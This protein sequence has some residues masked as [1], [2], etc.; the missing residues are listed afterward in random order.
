MLRACATEARRLAT[1][2][3]WQQAWGKR[4]VAISQMGNLPCTL[5]TGE[6]FDS[7]AAAIVPNDRRTLACDLGVLLVARIS[8]QK[9]GRLTRS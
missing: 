1:A 5:Y 3:Q 8:R 6:L 2:D 9:F 4:G 7:N